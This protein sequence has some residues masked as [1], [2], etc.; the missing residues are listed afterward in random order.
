MRLFTKTLV[1]GLIGFEVR[2]RDAICA[3]GD[4]AFEKVWRGRVA[5]LAC[6]VGDSVEQRGVIVRRMENV[7]DSRVDFQL[8]FQGKM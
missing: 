8:T 5:R 2:G 4:T 3:N 6:D 1:V 7:G